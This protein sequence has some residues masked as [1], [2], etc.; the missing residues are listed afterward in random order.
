M[1]CPVCDL[2]IEKENEQVHHLERCH[3]D[4]LEKRWEEAGLDKL[5]ITKQF[6]TISSDLM[7]L[8]AVVDSCLRMSTWI[9]I[10]IV[11]DRGV[12]VHL[13]PNDGSMVDGYGCTLYSALCLTLD[14]MRY[15]K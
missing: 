1:K 15:A 3:P 8:E 7:P 13:K 4:F 5:E 10:S 14:K 9:N 6:I 11:P 12:R 2:E